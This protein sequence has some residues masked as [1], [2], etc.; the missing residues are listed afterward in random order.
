MAESESEGI[1]WSRTSIVS[2]ISLKSS[3]FG[4]E[5]PKLTKFLRRILGFTAH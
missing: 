1:P 5:V 3:R 2:V 4:A